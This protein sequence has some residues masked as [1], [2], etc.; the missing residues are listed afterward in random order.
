MLIPQLVGHNKACE[1][2]VLGQTFNAE[3]A[4]QFGIVNHV[5]HSDEHFILSE[6]TALT[7]ANLP[8]DA[9]L[10]S[11]KLLRQANKL[12]LDQVIVNEVKDFSRLVNTPECKTI[13]SQFFK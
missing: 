6:K 3:Q 5:C 11:K 9:V 12:V 2:M 8:Q 1:L 4:C 10:T 7:I 13:L